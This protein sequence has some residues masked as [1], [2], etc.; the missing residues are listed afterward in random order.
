MGSYSLPGLK[1]SLS[2]TF[3]KRDVEKNPLETTTKKSSK[4]PNTDFVLCQSSLLC[5]LPDCL[6][7][8]AQIIPEQD[9]ILFPAPQP[10]QGK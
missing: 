5:Y 7:T 3:P 2:E 10:S 4:K 1:G 9:R 6:P 8:N